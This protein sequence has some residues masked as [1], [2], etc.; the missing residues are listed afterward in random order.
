MG[1]VHVGVTFFLAFLYIH[2]TVCE[3]IGN[4]V[5]NFIMSGLFFKSGVKSMGVFCGQNFERE[6]I[7]VFLNKLLLCVIIQIRK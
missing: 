2:T 5:T 3:K 7:D 4:K 1:L 6:Y